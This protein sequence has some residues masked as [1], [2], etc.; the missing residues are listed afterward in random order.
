MNSGSAGKER[1]QEIVVVTGAST[2][3]G[4]ATA[5]AL[6]ARGFHVLAGIRR[7]MDGDAIRAD[8]I[9]PIMLDITDA[10]AITALVQ[11]ITEDPQRRTLRALV[12]NA[13]V[14]VNAPLETYA[15]PEWRRLFEVNLFGHVAMM[16][17]LLPLLIQSRGTIVNISS[18]G[19]RVAMATYGP[20]A[21]TKFALEAV[22]DSL[23]REVG[24]LGVKVVVIEPG[25]VTTGMLGRVD[26]TGQR[27]VSEMTT[28]QRGRYG[29]LMQAVVA[30]AQASVSGGATA[31]NVATII[32]DA[33]VSKQ[34]RTRYTVG[35]ST[36]M[37]ARLI[38]ILPDRMLDK[39]LAQGL[40]PYL[41]K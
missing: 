23:R 17:A 33:I 4:A 1:R 41:P 36:A 29:A 31:E 24:S 34:P 3:I 25:A 28:E 11:H 26:A 16:Q 39:L 6:A 14:A 7:E 5:R 13:G 35:R 9:E 22:S 37:I 38:R 32:A 10:D 20:Y 40:K 30:Q 18:V 15:L 12:N 2:G 21:A 8:N 19:G 27:V